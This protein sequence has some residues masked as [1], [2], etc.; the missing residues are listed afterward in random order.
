MVKS[1]T[2]M[3]LPLSQMRIRY[4]LTIS[5]L[6]QDWCC[7]HFCFNPPKFAKASL[8]LLHFQGYPS[9]PLILAIHQCTSPGTAKCL[10]LLNWLWILTTKHIHYA[11]KCSHTTTNKWK[12]HWAKRCCDGFSC[13]RY[14]SFSTHSRQWQLQYWLTWSHS[15]TNSNLT[16]SYLHILRNKIHFKPRKYIYT[17]QTY[18]DMMML[19][20]TSSL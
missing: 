16:Y 15:C 4:K 1:T 17:S 13:F 14:T 2:E 7:C 6:Q 20:L 11:V 18:F 8:V 12:F 3:L 10:H 5:I 9:S 19:I